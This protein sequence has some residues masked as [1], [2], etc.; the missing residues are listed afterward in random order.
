[1]TAPAFLYDDAYITLASAQALWL[2]HDPHFPGTPPLYGVTSPVHCIVVAALLAVLPPLWALLVSCLCGT[3]IYTAGLWRLARH[4]GMGRPESCALVVSG[5][6][7]GM[8]SQHLVNGLETSGALAIVIWMLVALR[9]NRLPLLAVLA[10]VAPFVRPELAVL[11]AT[12][13]GWQAWHAPEERMRLA[14]W[15]LAAAIP[16]LLLLWIQTGATVPSTLWAKRDWYAEG[17]WPVTRRLA[18]VGSG[19]RGWLWAM[20]AVSVGVW[21]LLRSPV[22]R[23]LVGA[24]MV[25][26]SAW[27]WS[28]P[29]VLHA[30]QRHRYYAVL[31]PLLIFGLATLPRWVRTTTVAVSGGMALISVVAVAR[32]EPAA[33]ARAMD[34]RARVNDALATRRAERVLLHDAGYLA[35]S[36]AVP[37]GIDMVGLKTPEAAMLHSRLTGPSCGTSRGEAVAR[38]AA[39]TRP[40]HLVIW[41]PWDDH[42][43]ITSALRS[44]GWHLALTDTIESVEPVFVYQLAMPSSQPR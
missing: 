9:T 1:M 19:L 22:G 5:L 16:W 23:T 11:S 36:G 20:P 18:V 4:E 15:S 30:Y 41:G 34:V 8:V 3:A 26:L 14:G 28:V 7:A 17:C 25:I 33:I 21:G 38:L 43:G 40:T 31:L 37:T 12:L 10:G 35:F 6:G 42:F 39:D 24:A 13:L 27:A 29:N 44:A 2:G 32:F